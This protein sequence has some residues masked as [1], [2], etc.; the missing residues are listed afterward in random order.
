[1]CG[2]DIRVVQVVHASV[3]LVA[4]CRVFVHHEH[5]HILVPP[6]VDGAFFMLLAE[7]AFLRPRASGKP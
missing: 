1:M 5:N 2:R 6:V 3:E 4:V 7:G